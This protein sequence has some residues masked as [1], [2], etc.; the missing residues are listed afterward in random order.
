LKRGWCAPATLY[1][2]IRHR[3][4]SGR[5]VGASAGRSRGWRPDPICIRCS[6]G[7]PARHLDA[8]TIR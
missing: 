2:G 6:R 5:L 8:A 4:A 7:I 3:R 1:L